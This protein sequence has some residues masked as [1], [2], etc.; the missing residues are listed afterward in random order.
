MLIHGLAVLLYLAF[1]GLLALLEK[2]RLNGV[3]EPR[4]TH[5]WRDS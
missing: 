2:R 3:Q 4:A 5:C 1:L